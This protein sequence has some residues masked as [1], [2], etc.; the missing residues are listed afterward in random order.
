MKKK[1]LKQEPVKLTVEDFPL[2]MN[3]Q[4]TLEEYQNYAVWSSEEERATVRKRTMISSAV[5]MIA[6]V[7]VLLRGL[8]SDWVYHDWL[9]IGGILLMAYAVLDLFYQLL[10]F[11][12]VLKRHMAKE[13]AKDPRFSREMTFCFTDDHMVSFYKGAHQG[14]FFYDEVV[15]KEQLHDICL[16]TLNSGK[17][18]V[19]PNR[20]LEQADPQIKE[21]VAHLGE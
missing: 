20:V 12:T 15:K 14:T 19:F 7:L 17:I 16:L 6:G 4:V 9:T 13:Y 3:C 8:N 11:K 5:L 18:M 10:L 2:K 21:I 1:E